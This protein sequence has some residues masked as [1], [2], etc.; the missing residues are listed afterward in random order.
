MSGDGSEFCDESEKYNDMNDGKICVSICAETFEEIIAK[1]KLAEEFADVVEVRFDC[2]R[3][4]E[5]SRFRSQISDLKFKKPVLATFRSPE[6]GGTGAATVDERIAF[7]N[8]TSG[9]FWAIDLEKDIAR[10]ISRGGTRIASHHDFTGVPVDIDS[11]FDRLAASACDV[12]KI[13]VT[14]EDITDSIDLWRLV[15]RARSQGKQVIP[16]AMGEAGKWTRILG[17]AHG[18]FLSYASLD[19][20]DETAP[21]QVNVRDLANLYRVKQLD[22]ETKV[23]GILGNP[24]SQSLSTYMHNPAFVSQG[25][26]GVFIPFL[27]KN[28]DEFMRRMVLPETREVE[29]NF[30]GFSV[31][32]PHKQS[33]MKHL[34]EIDETAAKIGAV[35]SVKIGEDGKLTGY[36][37]DAHGFITPLK[38]KYGDLKGAKTAVFGA[39]G[40]AR[41]C[42][43]ALQQEGADVQLFVRD[44]AKGQAFADEFNVPIFQILNFKSQL[45]SRDIE[46]QNSKI[47]DQKFD[48]IV[49]TTP[50]GMSGE[51]ENKSLLTSD[52]LKGVKFVYDLVTK[53]NDTP[54]IREA[55]KAGIPA[56]GG[57]EMLVAQGAKQFE[58]WTGKQA[59]VEQMTAAV[60]ARFAELNR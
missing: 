28:I 18:A 60:L 47:K 6:Q 53:P 46:D 23:H 29:L 55:K 49:D 1:T 34:D 51:H 35:N 57:L 12:V 56:I 42:V 58:I 19:A 36:N 45:S 31:T 26:N 17:L 48:I 40:A 2:L 25:F 59:P 54:I 8:E 9:D 24:V 38:A 16:I 50:L 10:S 14:V 43:Y 22:C 7:W 11:I 4:N 21:G 41:A 15:E 27:V 5:L 37:T 52:E 39:G 20:G 32:M 33:I 13:A 30:C 3:A 44:I